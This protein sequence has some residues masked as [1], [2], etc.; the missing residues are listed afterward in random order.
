MLI[1]NLTGIF[2]GAGFVENDGRHPS[3][4]HA[5]F[6][7]G[8][9][10]VAWCDTSNRVLAVGRNLSVDSSN[11]VFN[12]HG[13]VALPGF[14]DSHTHAVFAGD[15]ASEYFRRWEGCSYQEIAQKGGGIQATRRQTTQASD[16]RLVAELAHRF[17]KMVQN[18]TAV[19][20]VKSGYG[21]TAEEE[22][23]LLR[24]IA[25]AARLV[26][27][28]HVVP[29]FL[30]LHFVPPGR[31]EVD[32][33]SEMIG[34]L[35]KI[36]AERLARFVDSF[37]EPGF[38][39]LAQS[40]RF[41]GAGAKHDLGV[42][43]HADEMSDSGT[44]IEFMKRGAI[45]VDH[46]QH[47]SNEA[48]AALGSSPTVATLLPAT[49]FYLSIPYANARGLIAAGAKVALATDYNPGTA[50]CASMGFTALLAAAHLRM[51]AAEIVCALTYNAASALGLAEDYG[52]LA[53][54]KCASLMLVDV[55]SGPM[56]SAQKLLETLMLFASAQV[57]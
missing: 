45:S 42:K 14:I 5:D 56:H 21:G 32:Y 46:L 33:C 2:T 13:K 35:P 3:I 9:V 11:K 50:P 22:L 54:G 31:S 19:V 20:E 16:E 52:S 44:A 29:T 57:Y 48:I 34:L 51:T 12:G 43:V 1:R 41:S 27:E 47:I 40:L 4:A 18:R 24:I 55:A 26:R 6:H 36:R 38:F 23:R 10:D 17:R 37:P 8:P 49:S 28:L 25:E 15:R 30:G 7:H 39:S 53:Q